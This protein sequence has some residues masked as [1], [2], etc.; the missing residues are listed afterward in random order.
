MSKD[1]IS[2]LVSPP[3]TNCDAWL[4][5]ALGPQQDIIYKTTALQKNISMCLFAKEHLDIRQCYW[6]MFCEL[7]LNCFIRMCS[8][9]Y[10]VKSALHTNIFFQ[11]N[12]LYSLGIAVLASHDSCSVL[13]HTVRGWLSSNTTAHP[14][15]LR[16]NYKAM[17]IHIDGGT[18]HSYFH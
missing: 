1:W 18:G 14:P 12:H 8:T 4:H 13:H 5:V 17:W 16:F 10:G 7:M 3:Y 15:L 2:L 11:D 6:R 9:S